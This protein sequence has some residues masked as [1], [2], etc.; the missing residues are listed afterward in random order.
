V[1]FVIKTIKNNKVVK[2]YKANFW[3]SEEKP[4][5][6]DKSIEDFNDFDNEIEVKNPVLERKSTDSIN[7][8]P[9]NVSIKPH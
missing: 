2:N 4:E 1:V 3:N 5:K 7:E 6:I 9:Q 8:L